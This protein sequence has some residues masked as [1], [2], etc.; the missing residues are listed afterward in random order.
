MSKIT[1][2]NNIIQS[3]D[4]S[5]N[6]IPA[7]EGDEQHSHMDICEVFNQRLES[8]KDTIIKCGSSNNEIDLKYIDKLQ[9]VLKL[10][11]EESINKALIISDL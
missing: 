2:F 3:I 11:D 1:K 8:I 10:L 7:I 4:W 9:D 5:K 6:R